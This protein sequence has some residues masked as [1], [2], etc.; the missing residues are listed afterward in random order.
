MSTLTV[1]SPNATQA[2]TFTHG[3]TLLEALDASELSCRAGCRGNGACGLCLVRI[4][5]GDG[6]EPTVNERLHLDEAGLAEGKRL[7]C[8]VRPQADLT[9]TL[10][11]PERRSAW[12]RLPDQDLAQD[13]GQNLGQS[14]GQ[15]NNI[16][17]TLL[18][19]GARNGPVDLGVAVDLGTTHI[20]VSVVD[21]DT[22][23]RLT[24]RQG[25]NP[26]AYFGADVMTRLVAAAESGEH[27][28][29]MQSV[30]LDALAAALQDI[31]LRDGVDIGRVRRVYIV[32]NT[33]MLALLA[34]RNCDLLLLP[35]SW[36]APVDCTPGETNGWARALG[37][38]PEARIELIQPLAG[39]VG[40]DLL[41]GV[42]DTGLIDGNRGSLFIDFGTNSEIALWDGQTLWATSVAG[43]PAFE[44]S[45]SSCGFPGEPGA[46]RRI[47]RTAQGFDFE[48]IGG[49]EPLGICGSGFVDL[50]AELVRTGLL[51]AKGR[52]TPVIQNG[53]FVLVPG[54]PNI[55][56]TEADVDLF[57]RAKAALGAG[58]QALIAESGM[59]RNGLHRVCIG[60]VFGRH[61]DTANAQAVGLLPGGP[62]DAIELFE[63]AALAGCTKMLLSSSTYRRVARIREQATMVNLSGYAGFEEAYVDHLFLRPMSVHS[64]A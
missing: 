31:A 50:I 19:A 32:G 47:R 35:R 55:G 36:S 64:G 38:D 12:R 1:R 9:I 61:L 62:P 21:L 46:I 14:L 13:L 57:Q 45:G 33:A 56:L 51:T 26:Q 40:S 3:Q 29:R 18:T 17:P 37:I 15:T 58:I 59:D 53:R 22:G 39:F 52:F 44:G 41:A 16:L 27:L 48:V 20:R 54:E 8:Q 60:G 28:R 11:A 5:S 4:E 25:L 10:L 7:A 42:L 30:V 34:T 24:G 63:G 49:Q 2:I 43:G 23:Q 6:G